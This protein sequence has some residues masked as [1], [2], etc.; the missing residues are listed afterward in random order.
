MKHLNEQEFTYPRKIRKAEFF[1]VESQK[2]KTEIQIGLATEAS[3]EHPLVNEDSY[4]VL[5]EHGLIMVADGVGGGIGGD[6]ASR[7]AAQELTRPNPTKHDDT[8][9]TVMDAD[10][11]KPL[12]TQIVEDAFN[13]TL[14]NMQRS[15]LEMQKTPEVIQLAVRTALTQY[16]QRLDPNNPKDRQKVLN[17]AESMSCTAT[18]A[19]TWMGQNGKSFITFGNV[20]DSRIQAS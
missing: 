4:Y 14:E 6:L 8:M 10:R 13:A 17:L 1:L 11:E 12:N 16:G 9:R 20:G 7:Q 5:E 3:P 2:E 18:L 15:I 19:K